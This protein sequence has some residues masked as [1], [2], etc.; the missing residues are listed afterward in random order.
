MKGI[1]T[2]EEEVEASIL[3][4]DKVVCGKTYSLNRIYK[5]IQ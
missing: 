3:A 4:D 1:K 2:G 5:T